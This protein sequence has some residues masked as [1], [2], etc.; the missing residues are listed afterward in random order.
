MPTASPM[1]NAFKCGTIAMVIG[2]SF[3]ESAGTPNSLSCSKQLVFI[4]AIWNSR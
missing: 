3:A 4:I 2:R 1:D